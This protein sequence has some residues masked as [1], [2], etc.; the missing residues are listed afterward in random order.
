M[1]WD[2]SGP[3]HPLAERRSG[4]SEQEPDRLPEV[5]EL[6]ALG[7][8][9][10]PETYAWIFLPYVWPPTARTWVPDRGT[11]WAVETRLDGHGHVV[12]VEC[13]PLAG[14]DLDLLEA[15]AAEV[16]AALGLPPRPR[17]RVW[18]LRPPGPF[19]S[20]ETVLTHL[21]E[22]ARARGVDPDHPSP[23]LLALTRAELA[24]LADPT[25]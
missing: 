24:A 4:H 17:G 20:V 13:A 10:A 3:P 25:T 19:P 23:D 7:W 6:E 18:L 22:L 21:T 9:P 1:S 8:E 12:E 15:E 16:I 11:R 14:P 5:R 2:E